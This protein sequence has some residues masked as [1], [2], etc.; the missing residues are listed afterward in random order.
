MYFL[1]LHAYGS[2]CRHLFRPLDTQIP[3]MSYKDS[4][5]EVGGM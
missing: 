1:S 5:R 2:K 3:L 4:L